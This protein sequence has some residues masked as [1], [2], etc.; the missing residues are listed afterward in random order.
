MSSDAEI[1]TVCKEDGA[2]LVL[3]DH[4]LKI[5]FRSPGWS[6]TKEAALEDLLECLSWD[7]YRKRKGQLD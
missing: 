5:L 7:L 3:I 1:V 2:W 6:N 4:D